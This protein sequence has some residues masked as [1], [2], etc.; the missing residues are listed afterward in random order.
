M[1]EPRSPGG[2]EGKFCYN[3]WIFLKIY[4]L[5]EDE[6]W[7]KNCK[8][9][10]GFPLYSLFNCK[11]KACPMSVNGFLE[12]KNFVTRKIAGE[13]IIVPVRAHVGELDSVYTLN[14]M[15][16]LIW[17]LLQD[18]KQKRD[19]PQVICET[20]EI[21]PDQAEADVRQFFQSLT[22]AGLI[23]KLSEPG[24]LEEQP[25]PKGTSRKKR[26]WKE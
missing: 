7:N 6:Y 12:E 21:S 13:T 15:G 23:Q 9:I 26:G 17:D 22:Q 2:L 25:R 14:E 24:A 19:I 5:H 8:N 18:G 10:P 16:T 1:Q 11:G 4:F 3:Y 20:Y